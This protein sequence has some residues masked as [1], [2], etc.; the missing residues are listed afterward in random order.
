MYMSLLFFSEEVIQAYTILHN[1]SLQTPNIC[2]VTKCPFSSHLITAQH[3]V[4]TLSTIKLSIS[5]STQFNSI[6]H[7]LAVSGCTSVPYPILTSPHSQPFK[8]PQVIISSLFLIN[9]PSILGIPQSTNT[10]Y[11]QLP[12]WTPITV[13]KQ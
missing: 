11:I 4:Y 1:H 6:Q 10:V 7:S 9:H 12:S 2:H 5:E 13:S 8:S 3:S